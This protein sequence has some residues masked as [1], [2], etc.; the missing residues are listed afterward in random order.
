VESRS[1]AHMDYVRRSTEPGGLVIGPCGWSS[2]RHE[3]DRMTGACHDVLRGVTNWCPGCTDCDRALAVNPVAARRVKRSSCPGNGNRRN[4]GTPYHAH[5]AARD[6][7]RP[8]RPGTADDA[9][10]AG[11]LLLLLR[12]AVE[13]RFPYRV[14]ARVGGAGWSAPGFEDT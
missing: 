4:P 8:R 12:A 10:V 1:I 5:I 14:K 7:S 2:L 13:A 11:R 9:L 3:P 6:A